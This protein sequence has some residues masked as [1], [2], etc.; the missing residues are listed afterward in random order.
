MFIA[1]FYFKG[2]LRDFL[3]KNQNK[4]FI[5]VQFNGHETIKH[6]I[7]A[8]GVPHTE[9]EALIVNGNYV[10]FNYFISGGEVVEV[11]PVNYKKKTRLKSILRDDFEGELRFVLD[12]HLGKLASY[13]RLLGYDTLYRNDYEDSELAIIS[14]LE[15]RYLL[16]RD[17]NLLKRSLVVYG[18]WVRA[19]VPSL[20]L[21]EVVQ[22]FKLKEK[23]KPYVRCSLCNGMLI[24]VPKAEIA[25]K[26]ELKTKLYYDDFRL[27]IECD[28]IYWKGTHFIRMEKFFKSFLPHPKKS[29]GQKDMERG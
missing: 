17:Q 1:K 27:C 26:L 11:Y 8:I 15:N 9:V 24:E 19:Q 3:K 5:E 25:D 14:H 2:Q 16:T 18:Y 13:L 21:I 12:S 28:Q 29:N 23:T 6:L 22:R 4:N 10:G 7:E 20:Q